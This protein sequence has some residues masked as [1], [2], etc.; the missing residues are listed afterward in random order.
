[1]PRLRKRNPSRTIAASPKDFK[2]AIKNVVAL[3]KRV[4]SGRLRVSS[5]LKKWDKRK[6][7]D[8]S[9]KNAFLLTA[10]DNETKQTQN[11]MPVFGK[12]EPGA[13]S[14][15]GVR[16]AD[17]DCHLLLGRRKKVTNS[18]AFC[19]EVQQLFAASKRSARR[20]KTT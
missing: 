10:T 2:K 1:M 7:A 19:A 3:R 11:K 4:E 6:D 16:A 14:L 12:K 20:V 8:M 5:A 9:N 17:W 15:A 18:E 13:L